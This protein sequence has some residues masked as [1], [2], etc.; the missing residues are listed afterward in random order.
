MPH[1]EAQ[2]NLL[3]FR[4]ESLLE[5]SRYIE[6]ELQEHQESHFTA[7]SPDYFHQYYSGEEVLV[8]EQSYIY[9]SYRTWLDLAHRLDCRILTPKELAHPLVK[10]T[11]IKNKSLASFHDSHS[12]DPSEK[13]GT[14]S[15][16]ARLSKLEEPDFLLDYKDAL[17]QVGIDNGDTIINLGINSADEF[18]LI[19]RITP[20]DVFND[21]TLIGVDHCESAL[22]KAK[23]HFCKEKHMFINQ[24]LGSLNYSELP[25]ANL[26]ISIG[27]LQSS[28]IHGQEV[29]RKAFQEGLHKG[30]SIILGFPN[31][32]YMNGEL[33]YGA[34]I[35]NF[36][37][38]DLSLLIKDISYYK[39]YLQQHKYEVFIRGKYTLFLCATPRRAK[40]SSAADRSSALK[41]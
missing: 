12:P 38:P 17:E 21:I 16:F 14:N 26:L 28:A 20:S 1:H 33:R 9:R 29:F 8:G 19:E 40:S 25:K 31:C 34:K 41:T 37:K 23:E 18:K 27:T 10:F 32:R 13:Y 24:D 3:G 15:E 30:A 5:V 36:K 2:N 35:K 22:K 7:L 4:N 6:K 11:F 39:K